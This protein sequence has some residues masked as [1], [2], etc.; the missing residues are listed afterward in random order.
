MFLIYTRKSTDEPD[1]QKNSLEY[2]ER[3]CRKYAKLQGLPVTTESIEP[4]LESGI[5]RERHSA[6]KSSALSFTALGFAEYEIERPKF[7]QMI[8]WMLEKK[9]EGIIVLCWDRISRSEQSDLIVKTLIDEHGIKIVFVQADY[10]HSSSGALHRDVDGMFARHHSRV[11][12]EKV[13]HTFTKLREDKR[14]TYS[15]PLGYLDNGSDSKVFDPERAP[16]VK[17][18]FE[19]YATG[20]YSLREIWRWSLAQGLMTKPRR[21]RRTKKE[22]LEGAEFTEKRS[23]PLSISTLQFILTNPFYIG[24]L[25]YKDQVIDGGHPALVDVETFQRVQELLKGKCVTIRYMAKPFFAYRDFFKCAECGRAYSPYPQKGK[26]YYSSKCK[27]GCGNPKKNIEERF[28]VE[29]VCRL[30]DRIHFTEEELR[31]IESG[32]ESGL[33]RAAAKRDADIEDLNGQKR[34]VMADLDYLRRNKVTLLREETMSP[35]EWSEQSQRLL[36][37][38]AEVDAKL[39]AYSATEKEMLDFVLHFSDLMKE[40]S[41]LY[42][43]AT[44]QDRRKVV[45][46]VFSEL[47]LNNGKVASYKAKPE[48]AMLLD[49]PFVQ[50]KLLCDEIGSPGWIRTSNHSVNSRML[51]H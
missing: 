21:A 43:R 35:G 4:I 13:R 5:I 41:T 46:L 9:Y 49:R 22:L 17:R 39:A 27:E 18:I 30:L 20:E 50:N 40:L 23:L 10:E 38:L 12:S 42:A 25:R 51:Y 6:F 15:A 34:R 47:S 19:R 8:R 48:F 28:L 31:E 14:C 33:N 1:N 24:K 3:E 16:V 29:E 2:Q 45:H 44:A 7:M 26:I 32:A 37:E 11:T 36:D